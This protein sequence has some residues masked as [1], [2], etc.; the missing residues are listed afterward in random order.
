MKN[1][2]LDDTTLYLQMTNSQMQYMCSYTTALG[3]VPS[4]LFHF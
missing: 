1:M 3:W 2:T 4:F